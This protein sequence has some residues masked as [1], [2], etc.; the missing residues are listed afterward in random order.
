MP[1]STEADI[2]TG[3]AGVIEPLKTLVAEVEAMTG[4]SNT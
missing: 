4:M 3:A 2:P 1:T